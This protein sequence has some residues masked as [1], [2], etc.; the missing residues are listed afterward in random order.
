MLIRARPFLKIEE[1]LDVLSSSAEEEAVGAFENEFANKIGVPASYAVHQGRDA[2]AL[3]LKI[4]DIKPG[5]EIIV[6][7]FICTVVID[8]ILSIGAVPVLVDN[9]LREFSST[10][11]NYEKAMTPRTR[12]L[13]ALHL[14][15]LPAKIDQLKQLAEKHSCYVLEDCAHTLSSKYNGRTVGTFGDLS[16]FSFNFDKPMSL[17]QGGMLVV[18]QPSLIEASRVVVDQSRRTTLEVEKGILKSLL[19]QHFLTADERYSHYLP[20]SFSQDILN[21]IPGISS[22]IEA[23]ISSGDLNSLKP[24]SRKIPSLQILRKLANRIQKLKSRGRQ[25]SPLLMNS[26][27]AK[28]GLEQMKH[29]DAVEK[30]R[31]ANGRAYESIFQAN[32]NF[33]L[34]PVSVSFVAAFSRFTVLTSG[35]KRRDELIARAKWHGIELDHGNWEMTIASNPAFKNKVKTNMNL[36]TA[37]E[38]FA[39][40]I[41]HFPTHYYVNDEHF[42]RI[43]RLV[44][45]G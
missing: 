43:K 8:S 26:L 3:A 45:E 33:Q 23:F 38:E 19:L 40:R 39:E 2:L 32:S 11:E 36:L 20:G 42:Y 1:L 29:W 30:K 15:G 41:L 37:S 10:V 17:G 18:N 7:N 34:P 14:Y 12:A 27:R 9:S 13:L 6:P 35:S 24:I 16:F 25:D 28:F 5:D 22:K 4:I 31:L 21:L 44:H